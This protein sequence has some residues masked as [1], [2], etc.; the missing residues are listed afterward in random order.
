MLV[1]VLQMRDKMWLLNEQH[2]DQRS[3]GGCCAV[4]F[5]RTCALTEEVREGWR[6]RSGLIGEFA[7]DANQEHGLPCAGLSLYP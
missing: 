4:Q 3:Q 1:R 7:D 2:P 5:L 6:E